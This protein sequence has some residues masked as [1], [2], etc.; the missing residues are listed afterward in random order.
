M[1]TSSPILTASSHARCSLCG[2]PITPDQL[3]QELARVGAH[4]GE[5]GGITATVYDDGTTLHL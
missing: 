4:P 3:H 2:T 5:A 1:A